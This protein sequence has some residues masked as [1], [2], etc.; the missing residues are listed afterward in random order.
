[1]PRPSAA[2]SPPDSSS[3]DR[4][5]RKHLEAASAEITAA[6]RTVERTDLVRS[7]RVARH[8]ASLLRMLRDTGKV[9]SPYDNDESKPVELPKGKPPASL[10][11]PIAEVEVTDE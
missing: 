9:S 10:P 4:T 6:L 1:M 2:V 8:L 11:I 5:V 7:K 3:V